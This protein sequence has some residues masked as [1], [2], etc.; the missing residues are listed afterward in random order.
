MTDVHVCV[1]GAE[2]FPRR[3]AQAEAALIGKAPDDAA[4]RASADAAAN[5]IEPLED[6]QTSGEY[7]CDLVRA[8]VR[9]ALEMTAP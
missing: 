8:M 9:R 6:H 1:G 2:P 4:F 7:R 5:A 3:I